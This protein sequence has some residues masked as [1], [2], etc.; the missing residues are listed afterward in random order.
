MKQSLLR[1]SIEM[2]TADLEIFLMPFF[3][4]GSQQPAGEIFCSKCAC[5]MALERLIRALPPN[6]AV[7]DV[8]CLGALTLLRPALK[9]FRI[10]VLSQV[11]GNET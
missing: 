1:I 7:L 9:T 6:A 2:S 4:S 3:F 5:T 10:R 11:Q 8:G